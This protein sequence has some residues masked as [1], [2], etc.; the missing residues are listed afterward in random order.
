NKTFLL[1][2]AIVLSLFVVVSGCGKRMPP[3]PPEAFRPGLVTA[4]TLT[5]VG[6]GIVVSWNAADKVINKET[7]PITNYIVERR[8]LGND[9]RRGDNFLEIGSREVQQTDSLSAGYSL[10]DRNVEPTKKYEYRVLV[11]NSASIRSLARPLRVEFNG[12]L[13]RLLPVEAG[14]SWQDEESEFSEGVSDRITE[15][16][17]FSN[18]AIRDGGL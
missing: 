8:E 9:S 13:S 16:P 17:E 10:I 2:S 3:R 18:E 4:F 1:N 6:E 7:F 14:Q 12:A 15:A 5:G 11:E